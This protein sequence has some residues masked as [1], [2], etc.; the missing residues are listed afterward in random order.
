[1][2]NGTRFGLFYYRSDG[3]N[4][5]TCVYDFVTLVSTMSVVLLLCRW[6]IAMVLLH[7]GYVERVSSWHICGIQLCVFTHCH[8]ASIENDSGRILFC[9]VFF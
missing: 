3:L 1:M 5:V 7:R 4:V 6:M 2:S 8:V 9:R